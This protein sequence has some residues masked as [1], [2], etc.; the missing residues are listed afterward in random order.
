MHRQESGR[1]KLFKFI[2]KYISKFVNKSRRKTSTNKKKTFDFFENRIRKT[3]VAVKNS[4][5]SK[6]A[7]KQP[8]NFFKKTK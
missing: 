2:D 8:S 5:N 3:L 1:F 7:F 4:I 6:T